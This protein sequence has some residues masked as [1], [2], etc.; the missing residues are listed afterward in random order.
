MVSYFI[1]DS[2]GSLKDIVKVNCLA[3][4]DV[5]REQQLAQEFKYYLMSIRPWKVLYING[6]YIL[7]HNNWSIPIRLIPQQNIR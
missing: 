5:K 3:Q 6:K 4:L 2:Q 1:I 7:P